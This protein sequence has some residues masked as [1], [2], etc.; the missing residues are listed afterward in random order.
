MLCCRQAE[1]SR[2]Q[3]SM[4]QSSLVLIR[5][6]FRIFHPKC[7][8]SKVQFCWTT[9]YLHHRTYNQLWIKTQSD[10]TSLLHEENQICNAKPE[11]VT[12]STSIDGLTHVLYLRVSFCQDREAAFAAVSRLYV[13]HVR[14]LRNLEDCYDQIVHPQKRILLRQ[15]LDCTIG[16]ILEL[17]VRSIQM[18]SNFIITY[19]AFILTV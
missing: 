11:K 15:L 2:N 9:F 7:I 17:K 8:C 6:P 13:Q 18:A 12:F 3:E 14:I 16:R 5:W 10:V 1:N 4:F 19:R